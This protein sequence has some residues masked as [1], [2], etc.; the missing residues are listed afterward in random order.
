M[1]PGVTTAIPRCTPE[2]VPASTSRTSEAAPA[3]V[4]ITVAASIFEGVFAWNSC[5]AL[6][7]SAVFSSFLRKMFSILSFPTRRSGGS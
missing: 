3:P 1:P 2:M 4:P 6:A 5:S 7:R